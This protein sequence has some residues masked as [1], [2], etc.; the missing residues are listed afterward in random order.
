M[1]RDPHNVTFVIDS[2]IYEPRLQGYNIW[3][4]IKSF[5]P[6]HPFAWVD[7]FPYN[8]PYIVPL[9]LPSIRHRQS[10]HV[11]SKHCGST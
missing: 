3:G 9:N 6:L 11:S 4:L 7:V 2:I 10:V 1:E 8:E 5:N